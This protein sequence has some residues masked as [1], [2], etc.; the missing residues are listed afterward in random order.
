MDQHDNLHPA[1]LEKILHFLPR[2]PQLLSA[3]AFKNNKEPDFT[4]FT[5]SWHGTLDYI[6]LLGEIHVQQILE[7]PSLSLIEPGIPNDLFPS[8]HV[9]L[10][11]DLVL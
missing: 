1:A 5:T 11:V 10:C 4:T 2:L 8:D 3:Y 9:S 6:F 7:L